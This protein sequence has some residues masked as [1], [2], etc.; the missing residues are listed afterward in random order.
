M[1]FIKVT[2][3]LLEK[4]SLTLHPETEYISGSLG[5]TGSMPLSPRPSRYWKDL[6]KVSQQDFSE[7][8]DNNPGPGQGPCDNNNAFDADS[9]ISSISSIITMLRSEANGLFPK[10]SIISLI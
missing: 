3:E 6:I 8:N 5:V 2:P 7:A 9:V 10:N 4:F 1:S